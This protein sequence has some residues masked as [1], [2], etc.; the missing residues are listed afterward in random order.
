MIVFAF[1]VNTKHE[2]AV[3]VTDDVS[4]EA[5]KRLEI[6]FDHVRLVAVVCTGVS[7][8]GAARP[9]LRILSW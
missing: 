6:V 1:A 4:Q 7:A 5:R 8:C 9:C 3:M 2:L